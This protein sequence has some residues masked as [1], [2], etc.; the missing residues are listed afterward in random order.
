MSFFV[1]GISGFGVLDPCSW[2][3]VSQG[4]FYLLFLAFLSGGGQILHTLPT[5]ENTLPEVGG[6]SKRGGKGRMKF[7][8]G[9]GGS[10][11]T[12]PLPLKNAFWPKWGGGV[13]NFSLDVPFSGCSVFICVW[14]C[15]SINWMVQQREIFFVYPFLF[16]VQQESSRGSGTIAVQ[17]IADFLF[18]N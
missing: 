15:F 9:G 16:V 18:Q 5:P 10:K 3:G 17:I 6:V 12:P 14:P 1:R 8:L 11:Y 7:L 2:P 4:P 13:Y